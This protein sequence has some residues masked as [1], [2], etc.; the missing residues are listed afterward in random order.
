MCVVGGRDLRGLPAEPHW[1]YANL[2]NYYFGEFVKLSGFEFINLP[3]SEVGI[4]SS[5]ISTRN[6]VLMTLFHKNSL[7]NL[8][9]L[10]NPT[11]NG[12]HPLQ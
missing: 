11:N 3:K 6:H 10:Y 9:N 5:S 8:S 2:R 1:T 7:P 4:E 12:P